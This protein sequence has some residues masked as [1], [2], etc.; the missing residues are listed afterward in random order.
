MKTA[1]LRVFDGYDSFTGKVDRVVQLVI[2]AGMLTMF[3][4]LL[5]SVASRYVIARPFFWLSEG[6]GYLSALVGLWGSSSCLRYSRH[7]QV[8]L[9]R[10]QL[11]KGNEF[12]VSVLAPLLVI[13]AHALLIYYCYV[14]VTAG[15]LFAD[16]GRFEY[17][18]S[19]FFIVF[20]PRLALPTGFFLIGLQSINI[21]AFAIRRLI[22]EAPGE[23][24]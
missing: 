22:G 6:A 19:G 5:L 11:R 10:D 4:L 9:L 7:M 23:P 3:G 16:F 13:L 2:A 15:Y 8:N 24:S 14:M 18:P 1:I 17:S 20:W 21:V 12:V